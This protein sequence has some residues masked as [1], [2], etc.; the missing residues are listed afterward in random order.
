MSL[1]GP[2]ETD[3]VVCGHALELLREIPDE[4]VQCIVT[5]PPYFGLRSYGT[6]DVEWAAVSYVPM[7]G[8]GVVTVPGCEP[9]C[10]HEW[11]EKLP[12]V[13]QGGQSDFRSSGLKRDGRSEMS[14]V[15]TLTQNA[16]E[17]R[18]KAPTSGGQWCRL[19]GGWRGSLGLEPT[20]KM[21]IAHLVLIFREAKR[22]LRDDGVCF[23]V[24]GDCY[25]GSWGNYAPGGIK[26]KQ[27]PRTEGGKRWERKAYGDT[28][29]LPPT[30]NLVG[31]K[32][33]Q[34]VGIP[35]RLSFALQADGWWLR[36]DASW[37]KPSAMPESVTSRP[38]KAHEYIFMLAKSK[39]YHWDADA[40]R[41]PLKP[42]ADHVTPRRYAPG[43]GA[44]RKG[45]I[46]PTTPGR[47]KPLASN[48]SGRNRRTTDWWL[49]SLDATIA[50]LQWVRDKGG[51]LVGEDGEPMGF[52]VN[53]GQFKGAHFACVDEATEC[54]TRRGWQ[55]HVG[56]QKGELIA[57]F[58]MV[59]GKLVWTPLLDIA[60]YNVQDETMIRA[61]NRDLSLL[62][63]P[64]HRCVVRKRMREESVGT[65]YRV[66]R[67]HLLNSR[68]Y[69][70][71]AADWQDDAEVIEVDPLLA[72]LFGW[73]VTEGWLQHSNRVC[74]EQSTSV[75]ADKVARIQY[76]LDVLGADY[77]TSQRQREWRGRP[78]NSCVFTIKGSIERWLRDQAPHKELPADVL[79]WSELALRGL[80]RGVIGGDGHTRRDDNRQSIAQNSVSFIDDIQAVAV[81]LGYTAVTKQRLGGSWVCYLTR[82]PYRSLR[83]TGGIGVNIEQVKYTGVVWCPQTEHGTFVARRDGCVFITGNT[84]PPELVRPMIK[85]S[86][87][88]RGACPT[89]GAPWVRVVEKHDKGF[90]DCTFRSE[91][92]TGTDWNTN[93]TGATTLARVI[94]RTTV[95]WHPSCLCYGPPARGPV[96]CK[97]CGGTGK[98]A[99]L[100]AERQGGPK[101]TTESPRGDGTGAGGFYGRLIV[102]DDPCPHCK[103]TGEAEGDIWP[104]NVDTW[105]TVPCVVLDCFGGAGTVGVVA[106]EL[107]RSFILFDLS[108]KYCELS[109]KRIG[110]TV[111]QPPLPGM[112]K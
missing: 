102:I 65:E 37:I 83:G 26:G 10:E 66:V 103:G 13:S 9:E 81:R 36:S 32:S 89:C 76:L 41:I 5:S 58:D 16:K 91:H 45:S 30:A 6:E 25:A 11:G 47:M 31:L 72:E 12:P 62:L 63:T 34:L 14:R 44:T 42:R 48:P 105:L 55:P 3:S 70:P 99:R 77:R 96:P 69:I 52:L 54:L 78:A 17:L 80:M 24:I 27:R 86:T 33:K 95:S 87:S 74:I 18:N 88:A 1:I 97:R 53:P 108:E 59:S 57:S 38:T 71:V 90:A 68:H 29:F 93:A 20:V 104:D 85:S 110:K 112:G 101:T 8:L 92:E 7:A 100:K 43:G 67:A 35:W 82:R 111:F 2:Y 106:R 19:C 15:R 46:E 79:Q 94:E 60:R 39:H 107:G 51:M 23:V 28:T 109:R 84:F 64:D 50:H 56:L 21:F 98:R 75:N 40:V 61:G 22:V 4:S 73:Y 49:E